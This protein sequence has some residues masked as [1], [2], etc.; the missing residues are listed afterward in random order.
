MIQRLR[1]FWLLL[2]MLPVGCDKAPAQSASMAQQ[3]VVPVHVAR[4][5]QEDVDVTVSAI[6]W[7]EAY[8]TVTIK[9]QVDGELVAVHFKE[10]DDVEA[11]QLLFTLDVRP[12]EAALHL[13]EAQLKRDQALALSARQEADRIAGL[14]KDNQASSHEHDDSTADAAAKEAQLKADEAEIEQ[15][16]LQV[17]RCTIKSPIAGRTGRYLAN[18]G[19]ITESNKTSLVVINEI[20][21]I[22]VTFALPERHLAQIQGATSQLVV[23]AEIPGGE[24]PVQVGHVAFIDNQVDKDTG[25]VRLKAEFG[26][27]D[28]RLWPGQF[29]R[30]ELTTSHLTQA[31]VAPATAIQ[32]GQSGSYV[33]LV[34]SDQTVEARDVET[35]VNVGA[36]TV[37]QSGLTVGDLVV[38]DG[39]LRLA[40][41]AR[42]TYRGDKP[43]EP[44]DASTS[45]AV[46]P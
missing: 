30:V 13:A 18:R 44:G 4:V 16:R 20:K 34:K 38:T 33:Y 2:L 6:G 5:A 17:E 26:N 32:P 27:E 19:N 43:Q 1:F 7:V 25:M 8:T 10:G 3:P 45:G 36:D 24:G 41:G 31:L 37:I 14:F 12:Y 15:A 22:Y 42:V 29:V 40:P 9:P 35:S 21:P 23:K 46:A 39:Q 28:M 11:G